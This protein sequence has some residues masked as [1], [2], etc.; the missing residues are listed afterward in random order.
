MI[1]TQDLRA[2]KV[3]S[4]LPEEQL[5]WF[6]GQLEEFWFEPG[7]VL[8]HEGEPADHM[9][10]FFAGELQGRIERGDLRIYRAGA[11]DVT[12][13]LPFSRLQHFGG[14]GRAVD[15]IHLG[16]IHKSVFPEMLQRMPKLTE[17]LV[18]LMLDRVRETTRA[19]EQRDKLAALGKLA[20]GLA[21]ELNNPAAAVKRTA[22]SIRDVRR[23][24][25]GAFLTIDRLNLTRE[26]RIYIAECEEAAL[27]TIDCVDPEPPN[28]ME[29]ADREQALEDWMESHGV[30][31]P[32][33][34]A[35]TLADAKLDVPKLEKIESVVGDALNPVLVRINYSFLAGRMIGEVEHGASRI[36]ELVQAV[37]EYTYMDQAPEQEIDIHSGLESTLTILAYKLRRKSIR[38]VQRF[39]RSIPKICAFGVELNQVWTNLIVNAIDAMSEGGELK[40]TT[41]QDP[42]DVVVEVQD[43]GG[44]IEPPV[45]SR[46]FDPFFTTK[47]VGEG[48]GLGLDTSMRVIKKHHGEIEVRSVPGETVFRVVLPKAKNSA[49]S[50]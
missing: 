35:P 29:R 3:F 5:E 9:Y 1:T 13:L 30:I 28:A 50:H 48:T 44:G 18:A 43:N 22:S 20:A 37:K 36:F 47:A 49:N 46:I 24:L 38:V 14:T 45:V 23:E 21:H 39:D 6:L 19:S 31:E 16:R 15:R 42:F 11:G 17:R 32:W 2:V 27:R 25:R 7:E 12:G 8:F 4:D 34:L 10:I 26:Q 40:I 41:S 33:K